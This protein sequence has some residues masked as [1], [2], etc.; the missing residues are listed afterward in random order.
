MKR[1]K[2]VSSSRRKSRKAFFTAP[3][4]ERRKPM[5]SSLSKELRQKY[6]IRS[7]P[8]RKDDEVVVFRGNHRGMDSYK[9][10]YVRRK[11]FII[12]LQGLNT[13]KADGMT[14]PVGIHPSNVF[15]LIS[16]V[17]I[18]KIKMDKDR[19]RTIDKKSKYWFTLQ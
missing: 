19:K 15:P 10:I 8:V 4:H 17:Q 2:F 6:G 7:I 11:K 3:S 12:Q 13:E 1:S 14:V 18:V 16:K 5:S 9:V